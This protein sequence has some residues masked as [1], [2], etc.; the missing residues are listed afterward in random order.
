MPSVA[1][2][3]A[4]IARGMIIPGYTG[5]ADQKRLRL[6]ARRQAEMEAL[7]NPSDAAE[8]AANAAAYKARKV[9]RVELGGDTQERLRRDRFYNLKEWA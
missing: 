1:L 6:L 3:A 5:P 8:F 7:C 2:R 9:I 4:E